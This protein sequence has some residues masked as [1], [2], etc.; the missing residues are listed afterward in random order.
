MKPVESRLVV[1]V[2]S[3]PGTTFGSSS[4]T[5]A[6]TGEGLGSRVAQD[7]RVGGAGE[8]VA[9]FIRGGA[10][11]AGV[12]D[13]TRRDMDRREVGGVEE[14]WLVDTTRVGGV[15]SGTDISDSRATTSSPILTNGSSPRSSLSTNFATLAGTVGMVVST[16]GR[17]D[18]EYIIG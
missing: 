17:F 6:G 10:V 12:G 11:E 1:F 15:V 13:V 2:L 16:D 14:F 5:G 8:G 9:W 7:G 4:T 3:G 18:G